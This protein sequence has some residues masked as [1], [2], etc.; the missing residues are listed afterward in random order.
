MPLD[1]MDGPEI[2][3]V[4]ASAARLDAMIDKERQLWGA[5]EAVE[6]RQIV[7]VVTVQAQRAIK[8]ARQLSREDLDALNWAIKDE[9]VR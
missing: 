8:C 7:G 5:A 3:R 6:A 9:N 2:V 1:T 4:L